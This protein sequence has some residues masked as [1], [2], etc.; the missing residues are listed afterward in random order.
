MR[1][2]DHNSN[3]DLKYDGAFRLSNP[4]NLYGHGIFDKMRRLEQ[5]VH[6]FSLRMRRNGNTA[7]SGCKSDG[8]IRLGDPENLYDYEMLA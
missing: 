5:L 6:I 1:R 4:K 3:S 7:T 2:N 8:T